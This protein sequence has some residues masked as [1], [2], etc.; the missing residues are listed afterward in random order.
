MTAELKKLAWQRGPVEARIADKA[1]HQ[2]ADKL[3]FWDSAN[4]RRFLELNGKSPSD[5]NYLL[6]ATIAGLVRGVQLRAFRYV[7]DDE[8]IEPDALLKS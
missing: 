3:V 5:G 8:K 2:G 7:K 4:K 1:D 6:A